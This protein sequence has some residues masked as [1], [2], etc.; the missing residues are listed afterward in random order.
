M[1]PEIKNYSIIREIGTGGMAV[2]YEAE[3]LR[4]Q[5]TVAIKVLHPHLC[6]EPTA[7]ERFI[8]E[9]RAAA[10][11]DHPNVVRIFDFAVAGELVYIIMEY[12]PGT[13]TERLLKAEHTISP[14][15]ATAI[16]IHIAHALAQAHTLGIIHRDIKPANILLHKQ[17]RA[18]LSD[19]G[20]AHSLPDA[21]LTTDDA[22]AGTPF[23]MSPEQIGG[24]TLSTA[25][26]IY[27]W[28]ICWYT[29]IAG[30]LPY[31]TSDYPE[32]LSEI[33]RGATRLDESVM[34]TLPPL[35]HELLCRCLIVN[36]EQRIADANRLIELLRPIDQDIHWN[37]DISA[38]Y[39][40]D[41]PRDPAAGA[42][43]SATLVLPV[44][45]SPHFQT[46]K[47]ILF[48]SAIAMALLL[49]LAIRHRP[50]MHIL[51]T[52]Q[53]T[54]TPE[55][56]SNPAG[57]TTALPPHPRATAG[58][59][60]NSSVNVEPP[61]VRANAFPS[62]AA[63]AN[64]LNEKQEHIRKRFERQQQDTAAAGATV[65]VQERERTDTA[66]IVAPLDSGELFIFCTP[67]AEVHIG[68]V[69]VG[70]T[71]FARPFRLPVGNHVVTLANNFCE[72]RTDTVTITAKTVTRK[73][74]T[75][76]VRPQ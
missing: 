16:M 14:E 53:K 69:N 13:T 38:F 59:T 66:V 45:K 8:R 67:W 72:P 4:L 68:S 52:R 60:L 18:M 3:D 12:V 28:G 42:S 40:S 29:L 70:T 22:V 56:H 48:I 5:R 44:K 6:K 57:A 49:Y 26:D 55:T 58:D 17:G 47:Q 71:P 75:L 30:V 35:C 15:N 32:V 9:A 2:V 76:T 10:K 33:R 31:A 63:A 73:R 34:N 11:I 64:V 39:E 46:L 61:S 51:S 74:Y 1:F 41:S 65:P 43:P 50:D 36:P 37:F 7:T 62:P 27:S 24:K 21:R 20:L 23:F 54:F 19:F 25:T